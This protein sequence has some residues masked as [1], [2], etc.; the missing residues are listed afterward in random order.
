MDQEVRRAGLQPF[1][2][3]FR[4]IQEVSGDVKTSSVLFGDSRLHG[5]GEP[6]SHLLGAPQMT[7]IT[8]FL[9]AEFTEIRAGGGGRSEALRGVT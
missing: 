8:S 9:A 1:F 2:T 4:G 7:D 5:F 3:R 6:G